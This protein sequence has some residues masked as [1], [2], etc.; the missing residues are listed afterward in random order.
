[1]STTKNQYEIQLLERDLSALV[2]HYQPVIEIV[3]SKFITRG[4]FKVD[5]KMDVVQT[6]NEQLLE[7][8]MERIRQHFNGSVYLSTYFSKV[9]YNICLEVARSKQRRPHMESEESLKTVAQTD[10]TPVQKLAVQ[11]ELFRLEAL[12]RGIEKKRTRTVLSLKLFARILLEEEDLG[13]YRQAFARDELAMVRTTFFDPYDEMSDKEIYQIIILLFNKIEQKKS[14]ADSLR[15][16]I[17]QLCDKLVLL[18]N[19]DPPRSGH[20]R[21]TLKMLLQLYYEKA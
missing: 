18:L 21:E 16:W 5:E 3:V 4:F 1:M 6:V 7:K 10:W 14:D 15:K 8:K 2:T 20:S 13:E 17:N 12:L 11:D 9:V 19:G